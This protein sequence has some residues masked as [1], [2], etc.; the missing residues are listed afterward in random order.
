MA[1]PLRI[2]N[3]VELALKDATLTPKEKSIIMEEASKDGIDTAEMEEYLRRSISFAISNKPKSQLK[4]C[5]SCGAQIPL[6]SEYCPYCA[7]HYSD[8]SHNPES[9]L[10]SILDERQKRAIEEENRRVA[11]EQDQKLDS[12]TN[13]PN[14]GAV[15]PFISNV[16]PHCNHVYFYSKENDQNIQN[17]VDESN[18]LLDVM[19]NEIKKVTAGAILKTRAIQF[20]LAILS[21]PLLVLGGALWIVALAF[22]FGLIKTPVDKYIAKWNATEA[23][24]QNILRRMEYLYSGHREACQLI[25]CNY[26]EITKIRQEKSPKRIMIIF[27][28]ALV[29]ATAIFVGSRYE[30]F[31][32]RSANGISADGIPAE[33]QNGENV[34]AESQNDENVSAEKKYTKVKKGGE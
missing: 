23:R 16:C 4:S 20:G 21:L 10:A 19:R 11:Q 1:I 3:L 33:S 25:R 9:D 7:H 29:L 27:S 34:S 5:P 30:S 8:I 13:C 2:T 26:D 32:E 24:L 31:K 6:I 18:Q 14:C 22:I 12:V 15:R 28:I 17:M